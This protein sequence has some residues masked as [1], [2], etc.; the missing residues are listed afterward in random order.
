MHPRC[1]SIVTLLSREDMVV[2]TLVKDT[3]GEISQT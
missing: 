3:N 1:R 2:L